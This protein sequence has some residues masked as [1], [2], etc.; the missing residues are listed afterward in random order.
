MIEINNEGRGAKDEGRIVYRSIEQSKRLSLTFRYLANGLWAVVCGLY[1]LCG[2]APV[3]YHSV[4]NTY[5]GAGGN[6]E[7]IDSFCKKNSCSYDFD[8]LDDIVRIFSPD[9]EIKLVLNSPVGS[10][11]GRI[12]YFKNYPF[13]SKGKIYLPSD[14]QDK[15][16]SSAM[17]SFRPEYSIK[18]I[19]V[20]PGH[21]GKDPG[22]VA[23]NTFY[24]KDLNLKVCN[25]LKVELEKRGFNVIL[26]RQRDIFLSLQERVDIAKK[27]NA[28]FF[29]SVHANS[30]RARFINGVEFYYLSPAKLD[31]NSRS[32][33]LA[34]SEN[35][36][37]C[38][39][40][41]DVDTILWDLTLTKNHAL[42]VELAEKFY[43]TFK[44]LGFNV[45][46]PKNA[47]FFVLK[48][49]YAPSI[50]I[51]MGYLSNKYEYKMLKRSSY[52]KQI[53]EGIALSIA[54]LNR[55]YTDL[56]KRED[57]DKHR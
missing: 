12:I 41:Q 9:K 4:S 47:S 3:A 23:D 55:Q 17:V 52:Q 33:D 24:E 19:V 50:L 34:K 44:N 20:D 38:L 48:C 22:A 39:F 40:G 11:N 29:L 15:I 42:S 30:N 8:T 16:S 7:D 31:V 21:G 25:Y 10:I 1:L 56:V 18:T 57:T 32:V 27:Y 36:Y 2:C 53:A 28:D 13:Y 6:F 49:A 14:L 54:S 37:K 51:E 26:T 35:F 46:P 43:W 5:R 45:Q